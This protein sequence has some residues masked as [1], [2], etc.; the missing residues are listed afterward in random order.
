MPVKNEL[1]S[2][3]SFRFLIRKLYL[4]ESKLFTQNSTEIELKRGHLSQVGLFPIHPPALNS[5]IPH[6]FSNNPL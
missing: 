4:N 2:S 3:F 1:L 5:P 6:S